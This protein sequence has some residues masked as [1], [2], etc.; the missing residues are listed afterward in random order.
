M[1]FALPTVGVTLI[2][3]C[4]LVAAGCGGPSPH[5]RTS[6]DTAALPADQAAPGSYDTT[7]DTFAGLLPGM[8]SNLEWGLAGVNNQI[9]ALRATGI[10]GTDKPVELR[11]QQVDIH[12]IDVQIKV[13]LFGNESAERAFHAELARQLEALDP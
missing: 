7:I 2:A 1:R 13:G 12:R 5:S 10:T 4:L 11:A 8:F 6:P 9:T 3:F